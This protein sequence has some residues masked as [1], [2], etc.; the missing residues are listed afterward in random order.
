M[1]RKSGYLLL[2]YLLLA[3]AAVVAS[4]PS[5]D[6]LLQKMIHAVE[7]L[8]Y[9]GTFIYRH[10]DKLETMQILHA[11]D[12]RGQREHLLSLT[13]EPREI[14]K[15]EHV[16]TCTLSGNHSMMLEPRRQRTILPASIPSYGLG[17]QGHYRLQLNDRQRV[18][19]LAC[20]S[21]YILPNDPYRY[22]HR[23]CIEEQ[24]G[25]L[26]KSEILDQAGQ[27]IEQVMFTNIHFPEHVPDER[28]QSVISGDHLTRHEIK[29]Q[30]YPRSAPDPHWQIGNIP[31]GFQIKSV[32]R[33]P[34]DASAQPVQHLVLHDGLASISIF[35]ARADTA[36]ALFM[37][38]TQ[39]GALH[40][41]AVVRGEHQITVL[42]EVP[43]ATVRMI[44]DSISYAG[45]RGAP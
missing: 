19:G 33:R 13:G 12:E 3:Q 8:N 30:G 34:M 6:E 18:A 28:F 25:M 21:L 45:N 5:A 7:F 23:L 22:G 32:M 41:V 26:L 4:E 37:G 38:A 31:A 16:L 29:T 1:R 10:G 9:E 2:A 35:I 20:R 43:E 14:I 40:A 42:G 36:D 44:A 17:S 39:S 15:D 24:R 27:T 11:R